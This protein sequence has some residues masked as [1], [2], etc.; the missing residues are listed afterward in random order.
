[1]HKKKDLGFRELRLELNS[2]TASFV[3][4]VLVCQMS[5]YK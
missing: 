3:T 1:M 4:L 2:R 5:M